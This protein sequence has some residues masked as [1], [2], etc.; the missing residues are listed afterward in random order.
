MKKKLLFVIPSLDAGGAEK[1]LVNLLHLIDENKYDIDLYLFHKQGLFLQQ[2]PNHVNIIDINEDFYFFNQ[3]LKSSILSFIRKMRWDLVMSRLMFFFINRYNKRPNAEQYSW[4]FIAKSIKP[5]T[6]EYDVAIGYLEKSSNYF[7]VDKVKAKKKV[8]YIHSDY[9]ELKIDRNF[10]QKYFK[11]IDIIVTIS[12]YCKE[13]LDKLFLDKKIE[14][15]YNI[16]PKALIEKMAQEEMDV[17]FR[18]NSILSI[19]R[20]HPQKGF[21]IA[22]ET[23][24]FLRDRNVDFTWYIIGSGYEKEKLEHLIKLNNLQNIFLLLGSKSNPYPFIK[25][26]KIYVQPSRYEGKSIALDEAKILRKPILVTEF[27]TVNDQFTNGENAIFANIN[28]NDI[29]TKIE[30]LLS[31]NALREKLIYNLQ[32]DDSLEKNILAKFYHVIN[33]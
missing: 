31:D 18:D 2:V 9:L 8:A 13:V 17:N 7:V 1:S 19:G 22:I 27:S 30:L 24:T 6:K 25:A 11:S 21:D 23:A 32:S 28:A 15:I 3:E 12:E 20:L 33:D 16:S 4:K 5:L 10:D 14:V 26:S 29:A